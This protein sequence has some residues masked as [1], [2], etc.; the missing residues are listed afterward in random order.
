MNHRHLIYTTKNILLYEII[1]H[2]LYNIEMCNKKNK[3]KKKYI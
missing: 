1:K 3:S 2:F